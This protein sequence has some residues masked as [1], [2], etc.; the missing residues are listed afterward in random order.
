MVSLRPLSAA[1][2]AL[3]GGAVLLSG[4]SGTPEASPATVTVTA[5]ATVTAEP[6]TDP[7]AETVTETETEAESAAD[8][9]AVKVGKPAEHAGVRLTVTKA[10]ASD[11]VTRNVTN[12][13]QGSGYDKYD[14]IP[15]DK[16]GHFIVV[17]AEVKNIGKESM[18]LT[19][20]W[21]INIKVIDEELREF[22]TVDE[23]YDIKGNPECNAQLQPGFSDTITYAFMVPKD[24]KVPGLYFQDTNAL[25]DDMGV[26]SFDAAL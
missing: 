17:E 11:T 15:A 23:L 12:S 24:A 4:C 8:P 26:V 2:V 7:S 16:G 20:G 6:E 5:T 1:S 13:R 10:K 25:D 14:E 3:L 21:P 18:D 22:D 19:C 9:A